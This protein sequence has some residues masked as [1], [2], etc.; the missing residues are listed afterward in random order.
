[1]NDKIMVES[2]VKGTVSIN[3]PHLRISKTWPRKGAKL[4]LDAEF[5]KEAIYDPG[6]EYLFKKGILFIHDMDSKIELGLEEEGTVTPTLIPLMDE[7]Y[8][9]RLLTVMP[10]A[11][12]KM[13]LKKMNEV[14][15]NELI[16]FDSGRNEV[17]IDRLTAIDEA[18]GTDMLGVVKFR[19]QKED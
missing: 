14:Q 13:E 18:F 15:N 9:L 2:M 11:E 7:K 1:M 19:H 10:L 6:I 4:P 5:L 16:E 8:M 3:V 17:N 12:M